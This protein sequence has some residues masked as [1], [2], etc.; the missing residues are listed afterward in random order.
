MTNNAGENKGQNS[1]EKLTDSAQTTGVDN[2]LGATSLGK[3][4]DVKSLLN[5][6]N[7]LQS[8]FTRR[9]QR[10]KELEREMEQLMAQKNF[11][12][13]GKIP[14]GEGSDNDA[15]KITSLEKSSA[16]FS[17]NS[18]LRKEEFLNDDAT[19]TTTVDINSEDFKNKVIREYLDNI[20]NSKPSATLTSGNGSA[21]VM[22]PFKPK[23]ILEA[24]QL[25]K[26][27]LNPK[28]IN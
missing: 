1:F 6:Y 11:N 10:V 23:S 21:I 17:N 3:F 14:N 27:I 2:D 24:G 20:K 7:S 9:C 8:E 5:A 12:T 22:P 18:N 25:A 15:T 28:E 19:K 26:Q 4:K 16:D 13:L